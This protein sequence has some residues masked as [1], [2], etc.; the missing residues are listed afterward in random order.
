MLN[1]PLKIR[2]LERFLSQAACAE[3]L[4]VGEALVSRVVR[5]SRQL[6]LPV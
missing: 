1:M 5:G 4:G 2:I 3:V 6:S